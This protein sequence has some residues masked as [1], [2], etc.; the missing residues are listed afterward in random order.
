M[1][2]LNDVLVYG[3]DDDFQNQVSDYIQRNVDARKAKIAFI[4]LKVFFFYN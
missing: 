2:K 1:N 4:K 3:N